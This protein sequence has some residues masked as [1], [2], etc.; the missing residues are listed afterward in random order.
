MSKWLYTF[1]VPSGPLLDRCHRT[2]TVSEGT[3]DAEGAFRRASVLE[4]EV[5][6]SLN[7]ESA[8][9]VAYYR[10]VM[11]GWTCTHSTLAEDLSGPEGEWPG[12]WRAL[13]EPGV[14][15][16]EEATPDRRDVVTA[17]A[18]KLLRQTEFEDDPGAYAR[19]AFLHAFLDGLTFSQSTRYPLVVIGRCLGATMGD[20]EYA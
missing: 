12:D 15:I 8:R 19:T 11:D 5:T 10:A 14:M 9:Q 2:T 16:V 4:S 18:R 17:R 13:S 3:G 6:L 7:S 1:V 20:E